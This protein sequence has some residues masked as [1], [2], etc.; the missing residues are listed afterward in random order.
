MEGDAATI[1]DPMVW[2]ALI[3]LHG[4]DLTASADAPN[5]VVTHGGQGRYVHTDAHIMRELARW[6]LACREYDADPAAW[7]QRVR[8]QAEPYGHS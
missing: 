3:R 2:S 7:L 1:E 6:R 8:D 4:F 5:G